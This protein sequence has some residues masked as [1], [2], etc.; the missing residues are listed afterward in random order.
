MSTNETKPEN[1]THHGGWRTTVWGEAAA[2]FLGTFVLISFGC[3]V[4]AV[5]VATGVQASWLLITWGWAMAVTMGIYV[6]G[7]VTGA[8]INPAVTVALAYARGFPWSKVPL[9]CLAQVCGA[10]AGAALVYFN[11]V[12][13]ITV[14]EQTNDIVRG[15]A[16]GAATFGIFATAPASYYGDQIAGPLFDQIIGTMFLVMLVLAIT[17]DRNQ[18]VK[19]NLAPL[20]VGLL[21]AAIGMSFGPNAGYA[22]NPARDFGPRLWAFLAGWDGVALPGVNGYF[23]VPIVGPLIGG[24][25]GAWIYDFFIHDVLV[26]RGEEPAPDVEPRGVT[27]KEIVPGTVEEEL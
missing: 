15:E 8:H 9:Y 26:A 7:G 6:A 1:N 20:L 19:A 10:F 17:D 5:A 18:P 12:D 4:V 16:S 11:Y 14:F 25:V 23:W 3:G 21:V 27:D 2:E 22:I 13:A 24:V